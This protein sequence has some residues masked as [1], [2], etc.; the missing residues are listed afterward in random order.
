MDN[1]PI[2]KELYIYFK[3]LSECIEDESVNDNTLQRAREFYML[4][5]FYEKDELKKKEFSKSQILKYI[6]MGWWVYYNM[7]I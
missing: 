3:N 7:N 1:I 2:D 5:K 6:V 4:S